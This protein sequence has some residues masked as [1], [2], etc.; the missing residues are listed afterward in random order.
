MS[1]VHRRR[2]TMATLVCGVLVAALLGGCASDASPSPSTGSSLQPGGSPATAAS[3]SGPPTCPTESPSVG[4]T[5]PWWADR[6]FYEIFVRSFQDSDGD[7]IGDLRGI[8]D[9]LDQLNDGDPTTDTDLGVTGLW[10]MP[11]FQAASYHGYDVVDYRS[12]ERDY[13]TAADL[14][15]LVDAAHAR[16]I[17][18]I[19]DLVVNH[20][21]DQH[22]W[23]EA[24]RDA[25]SERADWYIWSDTDP[26]YA[27]PDG[28]QVWHPLDGR[29]YYGLFGAGMPDLALTNPAVTAEVHDVARAW[30]RDAGIDGYRLDAAKYFVEAGQDQANTPQ[31]IE[32]SRGLRQAIEQERADALTVG[33]I[34]D[35]TSIAST[36]VRE[37][38]VD[39]AFEFELADAM[40][41]AVRLED[42]SPLLGVLESVDAAYP[43]AAFAS[44]LSNHD[45]TRT[46]S[47]VG[48]DDGAGVAASLLLAGPGVP[49]IYY[50]EEI[51]MSGYKPDERLRTPMA[52]TGDAPAG[53][54]STT[55]PWEAMNDDWPAVN[56]A[57]QTV[58]DASLLSHYRRLIRLRDA[59]PAL[60]GAET[61]VVQASDPAIVAT[62]R[63][64]GGE[65]L[66]VLV[67]LAAT[68]VANP[69]LSLDAGPLCD[70]LSARVVPFEGAPSDPIPAPSVTPS[71]GFDGYVPLA[72]LPARS[73]TV[74][75]LDAAP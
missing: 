17:A 1:K 51:G 71:G 20:T 24:S 11:V 56:V 37:G 30:I 68:P 34:W 69:A 46:R 59:H 28:Q 27:G 42:S 60:R 67:N 65:T 4:L 44:F 75:R 57:S 26:G 31:T 54:F 6:T 8:I 16:G 35:L 10:L 39:L 63:Q 9:R 32:W 45:Q 7:G 23:F 66:L 25:S 2:R 58:D 18:V 36:Y 74:L 72:E 73:L 33:E 29:W 52:W 49:F 43:G 50:G 53:G 38:A 5:A 13:G 15:A 48:S 64:G 40:K 19:L 70:A 3:P 22:P 41:R 12:I 47:D 55:T 62:L 61:A 14:K 21:S